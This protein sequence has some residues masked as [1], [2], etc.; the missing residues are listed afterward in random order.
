MRSQ[1]SRKAIPPY[2]HPLLAGAIAAC[3]IPLVIALAAGCSG[4]SATVVSNGASPYAIVLAANPSP[5]ERHAAGELKSQIAL[6]T[7]AEIPVVNETDARAAE[8]PRIF[9]GFGEAATK[10]LAGT[11]TVSADSLGDEGFI[12]R[13]IKNGADAPDIIVAGGRLRGT[14]YG[15][16]TLLDKLGFRWYTPRVT[17][18]PEGGTLKATGLDETTIPVFMYREPFIKEAFDGD[19][20]ARNRVNSGAAALDSTRGGNVTVL[21]VH[22]FDQLI[23]ASLFKEHPEYFPLIGGERVTGYVQRCL[24]N[25][26]VVEIAAKNLISWMDSDPAHHIFTLSQNDVEK[27]CECPSARRSWTPKARALG[28]LYH[29]REPG[30]GDRGEEASRELCLHARLHVFGKA[31]QDGEAPP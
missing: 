29:V 27:Y 28:S 13:T 20:A 26:A 19:W 17:R 23:P 22:T 7:G 24:T 4:G 1:S 25:P 21:G 8:P 5:S 15:V 31:A 10:L 18:F 12:I 14:M 6:A 16:F 30:C 2:M 3:L 9:V 11:K